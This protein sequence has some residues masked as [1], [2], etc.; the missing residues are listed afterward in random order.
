MPQ[1]RHCIDERLFL[2]HC[3]RFRVSIVEVPWVGSPYKEIMMML[4]A[5]PPHEFY[6]FM[7]QIAV[8]SWCDMYGP[9]APLM[10]HFFLGRRYEE[11]PEE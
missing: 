5:L 7:T 9:F 3:S 1:S 10:E 8:K 11:E 4:V 6:W 2:M